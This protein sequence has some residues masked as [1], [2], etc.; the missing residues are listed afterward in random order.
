MK[1]EITI[2]TII[3]VIIWVLITNIF[4]MKS[5]CNTEI[6]KN[7]DKNENELIKEFYES[8]VA[9][10]ISAHG[11]RKKMENQDDSFLIVD[12]RSKEEYDDGHIKWSVSIPAYTD[13][14]NSW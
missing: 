3:W 13:K 14:D 2:W 1:K 9:V 8:E 5:I 11:L 6:S 4:Y 7:L 10:N 12:I